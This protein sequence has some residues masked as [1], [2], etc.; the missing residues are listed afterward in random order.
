MNFKTMMM[1]LLLVTSAPSMA[2]SFGYTLFAPLASSMTTSGIDAKEQEAI[3][4][5]DALDF[6]AG[7]EA[8][9]IL[10]EAI[11]QIRVL[12]VEIQDLTDEEIAQLI[13]TQ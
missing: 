9:E 6:L 8:S 4:K 2:A 12:N 10:Q 3:I 13:V 7:N 5:N 1:S 11:S